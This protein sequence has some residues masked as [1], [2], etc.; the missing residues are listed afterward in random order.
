MRGA[1]TM[2]GD[3]F[4]VEEFGDPRSQLQHA[5]MLASELACAPDTKTRAW[6][7]AGPPIQ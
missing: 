7:L 5:L 6:H 2:L 1:E 4:L 3:E